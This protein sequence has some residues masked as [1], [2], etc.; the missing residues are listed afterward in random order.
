VKKRIIGVL[1]LITCIVV[2]FVSPVF[3]IDDPDSD[4]SV[5]AVYVYEFDDGSV[6]VLIDYFLEYAVTPDETATEAYFGVFVDT[7]GATQ[8]KA[9]APYTFVDSGY[10]R[11]LIWIP[12]TADE[13]D[14]YSIDSA[15][16]ADY[17]IWLTGNPTLAWNP[18][19]DPPKTIATIDQ[20]NTTGDMNVQLA[21]RV[22]YYA[23]LLELAWTLDMIESTVLGN[24]LTSNGEEYFINVIPG[25]SVLAPS[26][27]A[28]GTS[29]PGGIGFDYRTDQG[30]IAESGPGDGV[31]T[32]SPVILDEGDTTITVSHTGTVTITVSQY[33]TGTVTDNGGAMTGSPVTLYPGENVL[34]V[35]ATG[36][37]D[38]TIEREDTAAGLD[39]ATT[40]TGFDLTTIAEHF[41]MSRWT[42][43]GIIW[44]ILSIIICAATYGGSLKAGVATPGATRNLMIL[45]AL[46]LVGG[47]LLG[48]LHP[49]VLSF[50]TI[51]YGA[52]IGYIFFLRSEALHKNLMFLIFMFVIVSIAGNIAASGQVGIASTTLVETIDADEDDSILVETTEGFPDSGIIVIGDEQIAY[53]DKDATHFLD[54][55]F[56]DI[57]RGSGGTEAVAHTTGDS[58]RTKESYALNASMDYRIASITDTAGI[59]DYVTLPARLLGLLSD[60]FT[61]PLGFLGTE[62]AVLTYI[63]G[64]VALG[65]IVGLVVSLVG[66]RRV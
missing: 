35:T 64:V 62:L 54:T 14:T 25:C 3:A 27:F 51:A 37:F 32:G 59:I 41:G 52:L 46:C 8:L 26:A 29:E 50:V 23:D 45:F 53:P 66:G 21:L 55:T 61:L 57:V 28:A 22:L 1:L 42:F 9:V 7:D 2:N 15:D 10:G 11:G 30:A 40:G 6:G 18:G 13:V 16:Q 33:N 43:S 17:R 58:V 44:V 63:W 65:V 38:V 34:T 48:L 36:T 39:D 60:F 24:K 5:N 49:L 47:A 31:V 20:W 4:P 19:P 12:F 56:S